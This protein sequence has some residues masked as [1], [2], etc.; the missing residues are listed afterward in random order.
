MNTATGKLRSRK[1]ASITFA[2]LLF[3]VCAVLCTIIIAAASVAAGRISNMA[4]ADQRYYSVTSAC[5][6]LKKLVVGK[7]VTIIEEEPGDMYI[8]EG[9]SGSEAIVNYETYTQI[10][11]SYIPTSLAGDIACRYFGVLSGSPSYSIEGPTQGTEPNDIRSVFDWDEGTM[12]ITISKY[13]IDSTHPLVMEMILK[14]D[15]SVTTS[16][17][18]LDDGSSKK[19]TAKSI[20]WSVD[21]MRIV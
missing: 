6:F 11:A 1:G 20:T 8:V 4:E 15:V 3:L 21:S 7:T 17:K 10:G 2:L 13:S 5:E 9:V 12:T 19:I 18:D 16:T 14:A